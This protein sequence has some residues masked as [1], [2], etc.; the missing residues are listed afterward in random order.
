MTTPHNTCRLVFRTTPPAPHVEEPPT[1]IR[2]PTG[3]RHLARW[4]AKHASQPISPRGPAALYAQKSL[5]LVV[6]KVDDF[7]DVEIVEKRSREDTPPLVPAVEGN[8]KKK[9]KAMDKQ[10]KL[11]DNFL[12]KE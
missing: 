6:V 11:T 5:P 9:K 1:L 3:A 7:E 8:D 2:P 4:M 12:K 10:T